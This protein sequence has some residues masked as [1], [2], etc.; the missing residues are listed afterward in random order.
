[1]KKM[2]RN[3]KLL[4]LTVTHGDEGF[5]IDLL[6]QTEAKYS[7]KE[8]GY[9]WLI[10]NP[11][12]YK[13]NVRFIDQDL[14]RSAPGNLK[15]N[16]YEVK[17]AAEIV[18]LSSKYSSV[19]D[20]HGAVSNCGVVT[21]IPFPTLSNILL[22]GLVPVKRNV[23]WYAKSSLEKG[24]LVQFIKCPGIE[25]EC[26][27]KES[28][29]IKKELKRVIEYVLINLNKR[30]LE[31]AESLQEKEFYV[32]Y[33]K[34]DGKRKGLSDFVEAKVNNEKFYPFMSNQYDGIVCY[35]MKK[36]KIEDLFLF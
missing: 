9:Q 10:S 20:I 15:S 13:Q 23:I 1:M 33:G 31:V 6:K 16:D 17:R 32:V 12:A 29:K 18:K 30:T 26:G 7:K 34:L 5:S 8:Y 36:I 11:K 21:I 24:P 19:I 25:I 2:N 22:A 35:K 28:P 4:F 14:N 3:E 27:P